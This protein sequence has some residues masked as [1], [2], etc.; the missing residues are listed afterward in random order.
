MSAHN[1]GAS[2]DIF[3][4]IKIKTREF[5]K[6]FRTQ[7]SNSFG[8]SQSIERFLTFPIQLLPKTDIKFDVVSANGNNGS[9]DAEFSI[10]LLN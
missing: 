1:A 5:G 2:S 10:A 7:S 3:Y 4:N 9:V 8:T 6:V